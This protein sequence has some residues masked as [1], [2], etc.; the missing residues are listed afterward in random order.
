M[1]E[2]RRISEALAAKLA[3]LDVTGADADASEP[4][5]FADEMRAPLSSVCGVLEL[6]LRD[7]ELQAWTSAQ[8]LSAIVNDASAS[9]MQSREAR[10]CVAPVVVAAAVLKRAIADAT[11]ADGGDGGVD[12]RPRDPAALASSPLCEP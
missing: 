9:E 3:L 1:A 7:P 4:S 5:C 12:D 2:P 10:A 8:I 6:A 11:V